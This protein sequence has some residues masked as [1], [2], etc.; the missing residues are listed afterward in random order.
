MAV[1]HRAF[2][3]VSLLAFGGLCLAQRGYRD[4][5]IETG[6]QMII[7]RRGVPDWELDP[8][9]PDDVFTFVRIKYDSYGGRRWGGG[10]W[11]TDYPDSDLNFSFR[12]QQLTALKV[13]PNPI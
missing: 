4:R 5:D 3:A 9:F 13:N 7:D 10:K 2:A 6:P 8:E 11:A 12:L 1:F